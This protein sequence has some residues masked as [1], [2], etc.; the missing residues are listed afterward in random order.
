MAP[1][2]LRVEIKSST[3]YH[4]IWERNR[5]AKIY[6]ST[7]QSSGYTQVA[8]PSNASQYID[9]PTKRPRSRVDYYYK[10]ELFDN[11]GNQTHTLGPKKAATHPLDKGAFYV[12]RQ[13]ERHL[14]RVGQKSYLFEEA[15]S[16]TRCPDCW[17]EER[18]VRTRKDCDTCEG[19]GFI[20]GWS[21]PI[22]L[23]LSYSLEQIEP[24]QT[25]GGK[26]NTQ[27]LNAHT[28]ASPR[29]SM[30]DHIVREHDRQ[31]FEVLKQQPSRKS[32]HILRQN[33]IIKMVE[34]GSAARQLADKIPT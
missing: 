32:E 23:Y 1:F 4:L 10:V 34:K 27:Q 17:D 25:Q 16:G 9:E 31:V 15:D 33:V 7:E 20:D 28:A 12:R 6:R 22:E 30:G 18:K 11:D 14:R 21:D 8:Q 5:D 3:E 13:A 26:L 29:I 19:T 2:G 24:K